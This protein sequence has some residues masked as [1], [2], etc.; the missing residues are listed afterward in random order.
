MGLGVAK[1][2]VGLVGFKVIILGEATSCKGGGTIV[3]VCGGGG[4]G[5]GGGGVGVRS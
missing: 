5:G 2:L 4:G 1:S 3:C